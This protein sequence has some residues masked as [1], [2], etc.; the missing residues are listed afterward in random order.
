MTTM[1][2]NLC[3]VFSAWVLLIASVSSGWS[4]MCLHGIPLHNR[5]FFAGGVVG[6]QTFPGRSVYAPWL[7]YPLPSH[8]SSEPA[9]SPYSFEVRPAGR[10]RLSVEPPSTEVFV[11]GVPLEPSDASDFDVALLAGN[12]TVQI[13]KEGY[14]PYTAE[15][16]VEAAKTLRLRITLKPHKNKGQ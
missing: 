11:D 14:Q 4:Q 10:L 2:K 5:G 9:P 16:L 7:Y 8:R 1:G 12:H 13:A 15:V 6:V 3:I